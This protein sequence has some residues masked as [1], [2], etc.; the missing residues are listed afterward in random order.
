MMRAHVRRFRVLLGVV[1]FGSCGGPPIGAQVLFDAAQGTLPQQQGW[2]Y[3]AL[4]GAAVL[5]HTGSAARLDTGGSAR[6]QAGFATIAPAVLDRAAGFAVEFMARLIEENHAHPDRAG[7]SVI[8][9]DQE[10]RG[11]ELGF[12]RDRV[13]AQ[14][15]VPLFTHAEDAALAWGDEASTFSLSFTGLEYSLFVDGARVLRGP[16]R[17]Y[18]AFAGGFDVYETPN[19]LFLGDDTTSAGAVMELSRV[20]LVRPVRLAM[21]PPGVIVWEGVPGTRYT[22]EAGVGLDGVWKEAGQGI[23]VG[24]EFRFSIPTRQTFERLRVRYP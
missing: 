23:S 24:A 4:P 8:V 16:L 13:F 2:D 20:A 17:D 1:V 12:W 10:A 18:S 11:I 6:E 19:F 15:D 5:A 21:E 3:V 22:V 9:L 14:A 7:F